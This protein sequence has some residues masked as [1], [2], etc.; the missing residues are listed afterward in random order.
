[1]TTTTAKLKDFVFYLALFCLIPLWNIPH[2]IAARYACEA[3]LLILVLCYP[4]NWGPILN[5][6]KLIFAFVIY[7]L[8]QIFFFS[9]DLRLALINF[10]SEWMHF[11]LF[12]L[13]GAGSGL[14]LAKKQVSNILLSV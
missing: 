4:L 8:I 14:L 6:S 12:S 3:L 2:T 11:I 5:R 10:K 13:V 9:S 1:M 7:L